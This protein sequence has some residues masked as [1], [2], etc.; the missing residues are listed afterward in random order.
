MRRELGRLV[1]NLGHELKLALRAT[2]RKPDQNGIPQ[3]PPAAPS[4]STRRGE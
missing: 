3:F 1:R 4:W 2:G